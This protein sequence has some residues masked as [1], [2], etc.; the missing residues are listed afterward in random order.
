MTQ[1]TQDETD[2]ERKGDTMR[3]HIMREDDK[4]EENKAEKR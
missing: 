4:R 3:K 1:E 2:K